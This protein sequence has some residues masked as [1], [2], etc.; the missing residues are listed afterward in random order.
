MNVDM[1]ATWWASRSDFTNIPFGTFESGMP[2]DALTLV[3][4]FGWTKE[5]LVHR[6]VVLGLCCLL[7]LGS[8]YAWG[9][10]QAWQKAGDAK[11]PE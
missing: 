5:A 9:V 3:D 10:W 2:S 8:V 4:E 7:A 1:Y 11:H 6:Y